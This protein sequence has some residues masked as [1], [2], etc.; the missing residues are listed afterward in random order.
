MSKLFVPFFGY[1]DRMDIYGFADGACR[2]TLNLAS[3]SWVIYSPNHDLISSGAICTG[4]ATNNIIE[5]QAVI[6][7][8]TEVVFRYIH[9]LVV[10]M[11]SQLVV[12]H[13]NHVYTIRNPLLLCLFQR[14]RL[15]ERSFVLSLTGISLGQIIQLLIH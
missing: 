13:L 14:V 9:D 7:L 12:C 2:H 10:F 3:I 8:L 4:P 15:L 1:V 11:D 5:Y 6:G